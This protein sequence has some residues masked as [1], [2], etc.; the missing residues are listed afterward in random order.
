[1]KPI[2]PVGCPLYPH[3]SGKWAKKIDGK[4]HYFG[5]WDDLEGALREYRKLVGET[6]RLSTTI[7]VRDACERFIHAK[8]QALAKVEIVKRTYET[9]FGTC[10]RVIECF[11]K[12]TPVELLG[13]ADFSKLRR[14][15]EEKW[16]LIAL[17]NEITRVRSLF[18]W[19]YDSRLIKEPMHFGPDFRQPQ[20]RTIRRYRRLR[21]KK[22]YEAQEIRSLLHNAPAPLRAMI[23]LGVN[24][25]FGPTDCATL[26][27]TA[28]DL[29]RGWVS[30]PRQK[31]EVEREC[32]LWPE[33]VQALRLEL[34]NRPDPLPEAEGRVFVLA[35]GKTWENEHNPVSRRFAQAKLWAGINRGSFYWLRHTFETIA[36][37]SK[38][39]VAVNCIM[40]HVDST[41]AGVYR[42]EISPSRLKDV[43]GHVHRWLHG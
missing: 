31:T 1:M 39:Q 6:D 16:N 32:P 10:K 9:Y 26:P 33:T 30:F 35:G 21:G 4:M 29:D 23:L 11:G 34:Q 38:D 17:G 25:G 12:D 36:G 43:V 37:D 27:L 40:G 41:M 7:T 42:E 14:A 19:L 13:P 20:A 22:L 8:A 15:R 2:K 3:N 24:C 5:R 28:L 18:K